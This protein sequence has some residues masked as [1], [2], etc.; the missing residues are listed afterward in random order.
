[1]TVRLVGKLRPNMRF[2]TVNEQDVTML[3]M[4]EVLRVVKSA[5]RPLCMSFMHEHCTARVDLS[6][7]TE[8][9]LIVD[10]CGEQV[11]ALV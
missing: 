10:G 1:M 3:R 9:Q 2:C 4:N 8:S 6:G 7:K 5:G 11:S